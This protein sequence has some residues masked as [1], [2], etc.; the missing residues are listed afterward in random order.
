[1]NIF[2][3]NPIILKKITEKFDNCDFW[4]RV[5]LFKDQNTWL[6]TWLIA[7][8]SD[9]DYVINSFD[10]VITMTDLIEFFTEEWINHVDNQKL[11]WYYSRSTPEQELITL[12]K[13]N[14]DENNIEY[15]RENW[16]EVLVYES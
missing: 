12:K 13:W 3:N 7:N 10:E 16:F 8:Y 11:L 14:L 4:D 5:I 1:M 2:D 15:L 6:L 9:N